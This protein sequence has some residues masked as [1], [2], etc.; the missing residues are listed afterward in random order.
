[1]AG[2][3]FLLYPINQRVLQDPSI[4]PPL[5]GLGKLNIGLVALI[6][7][8][9]IGT[10]VVLMAVT[11]NTLYEEALLSG[12]TQVIDGRV[13]NRTI[14]EDTDRR[15]N[16]QGYRESRVVGYTYTLYYEYT[17]AERTYT[18]QQE[19]TQDEYN[20]YPIDS[21]I[22][23]IFPVSRPSISRIDGIERGNTNGILVGFTAVWTLLVAVFGT[24]F[25]RAWAKSRRLGRHGKLIE[26]EI[27][28]Y[29]GEK[30][31]GGS[32]YR[33]HLKLRFHSPETGEW[34]EAKRTYTANHHQNTRPPAAGTLLAVMHA[35]DKVWEVL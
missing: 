21:S 10:A 16:A 22:P 8:L 35:D 19:V 33:V 18:G 11:L 1:M 15:T 24:I 27:V 30:I 31:L 32:G 28:E 23:I 14:Y 17:F 29:K 9:F 25:Y 5:L 3:P 2:R 34:V 4:R 12:D 6:S 26:G 20:R 13:S 7:L